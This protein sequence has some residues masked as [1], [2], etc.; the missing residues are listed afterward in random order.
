MILV[1]GAGGFIGSH[2]VEEL[3]KRGKKVRAFVHYSSRDIMGNLRFI[4]KHLLGNLEV[5]AGDLLY[6]DEV[7]KAME[8]VD[9][10]VHLAARISVKY[11]YQSAAETMLSNVKMAANVFEAAKI[12]GI[13]NVVYVSSSEVYGTPKEIPI[14][15]HTPKNAQSPY[16]ASKV[17]IDELAKSYALSFNMNIKIA[18]PFNTFGERQSLRAVIPWILYQLLTD[19]KDTIEIGNMHTKRDF[20]YV[21]DTSNF[22]IK[23]LELE[24]FTEVNFPRGRPYSIKEIIEIAKKITGIDKKVVIKKERIRPKG[25]EVEVLTGDIEES[26]KLIGLKPK[27]S[28][29]EGLHKVAEWIKN[30]K[31]NLKMEHSLL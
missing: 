9:A 27:V 21:K 15:T 3:L 5:F 13:E 20:I 17:A 14:T 30:N 7:I 1:T 31:K 8:H 4:D 2:V 26:F 16:A 11:S 18:R 10:V 24:E 29:E 22:I 12:M 19:E 28:I 6:L 23:M 25:S